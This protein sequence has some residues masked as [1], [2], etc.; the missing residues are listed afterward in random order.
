[1]D[2]YLN[3]VIMPVSACA[4][5]TLPVTPLM[6]SVSYCVL[7]VTMPALLLYC[8]DDTSGRPTAMMP[9]FVVQLPSDVVA[10]CSD[11]AG[12]NT[13]YTLVEIKVASYIFTLCINHLLHPYPVTVVF[14]LHD[15]ERLTPCR[16]F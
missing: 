8:T 6:W 7:V 5:V 12:A 4:R 1:M 13:V 16:L 2:W 9:W 3:L 15:R 14:R 11:G 10:H